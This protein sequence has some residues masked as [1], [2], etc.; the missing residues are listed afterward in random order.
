[1]SSPPG[2]VLSHSRR[3]QQLWLEGINPLTPGLIALEFVPLRGDVAVSPCEIYVV[4]FPLPR[5]SR[6]SVS[7]AHLSGEAC[8]RNF[9]STHH[10]G[11]SLDTP[12]TCGAGL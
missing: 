6:T 4:L 1:M 5:V 10:T 2:V 12:S 3:H 7:R 11:Y 8:P 9:R